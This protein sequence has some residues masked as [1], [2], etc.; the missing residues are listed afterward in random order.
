MELDI[1]TILIILG[2][3]QG[4]VLGAVILFSRFFQSRSN[5]YLAFTFWTVA[6]MGLNY[7]LLSSGWDNNWIIMMNDIMWEYLFPVTFLLYFAYALGHPLADSR[8]Q[9]WLYFPFIITLV[10]NVAI[11]LDMDFHLYR[12]SFVANEPAL[13]TYYFW[14]A[15]GTLVF[16]IALCIWARLII[17]NYRPAL[18]TNWFRQFWLMA[19]VIISLWIGSWLLDAFTGLDYTDELWAAITILFFWVSYRGLIQFKLAEEKFEIKSILAEREIPVPDVTSAKP[20]VR[21]E[22]TNDYLQRIEHLFR[23]RHL[24]RDPEL[25]RDALAKKLGISSGYLSQQ[26]N[27]AAGMNFS[28]YINTFRVEDV[29]EMLLDPE[30]DQYSLLSIGYEAGFNSKSTF[31]SAFKKSTGL[32]PSS[33][34]QAR[35]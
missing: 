10:M 9:Y 13:D 17:R 24:H 15:I 11:D 22:A 31:Y 26:I 4:F 35:A 19:T 30:F 23:V 12:W 28:D 21:T 33:F 7:T 29:K 18:P 16:A 14:E 20:I 32:T 8:H 1:V 25:N 2:I 27:S 3:V 34:R 5:Q 6:L